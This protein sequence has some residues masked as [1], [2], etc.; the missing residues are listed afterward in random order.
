MWGAPLITPGLAQNG[1]PDPQQLPAADPVSNR[2]RA[3]AR[4]ILHRAPGISVQ[5]GK[6]RT[7]SC[8]RATP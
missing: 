6:N 7:A 3:P 1:G 2:S 4:F 5:P 8:I